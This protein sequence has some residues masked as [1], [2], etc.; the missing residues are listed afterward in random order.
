[1]KNEESCGNEETVMRSMVEKRKTSHIFL[2]K[3]ILNN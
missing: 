2:M 1:M 3:H